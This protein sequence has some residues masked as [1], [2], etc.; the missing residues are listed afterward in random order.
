M[1][2]LFFSILLLSLLAAAA[3]PETP[4]DYV[5]SVEKWRAAYQA[6]LTSDHGWLTVS[7]LFWLHPGSNSFGSAA[8]NSIVL[9]PSAPAEAGSFDFQ[10]SKVVVHL[11]PG[12]HAT[13]NG[14]PVETSEL[15]PD[16]PTDRL[17]LGDLI[18]YV[19]ASGPRLAIRLR[20]KNS[21]LRRS[22]TGLHW[23]PVNPAFHVTARFVPY[24]PPK[25][26]DSQNVL[27]DPIKEKILG[28]VEFTLQG[29]KFQLEA[30]PNSPSG[31]EIVIR[32]LTSGKETYPASR[33]VDTDPPVK[34]ANGEWTVDLDFNKAYNPPCAYNP[35]TTCP[36]PVPQN[37]MKIA[38]PAGEKLYQKH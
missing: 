19:H 36:L 28:R 33:F 31:L 10:D 18:L 2:R 5:A 27:G 26:L 13:L 20:D 14:N 15:Q 38:I 34:S 17:V 25:D 21:S 16:A 11:K 37:R 4:S 30:G 22:F 12:V 24:D 1:R 7:G 29:Q 8:S 9:P 32:D 3:S 6:D 35:Y 23:F